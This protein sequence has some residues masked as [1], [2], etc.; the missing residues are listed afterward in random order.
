MYK[1]SF[2]FRSILAAVL[3]VG[4]AALASSCDD[5]NAIGLGLLDTGANG[6]DIA[7][8]LD[9][10]CLS[11]CD[12]DQGNTE[13]RVAYDYDLVAAYE[14]TWWDIWTL[15]YEDIY[16]EEAVQDAVDAIPDGE[17]RVLTFAYSSLIN[18]NSTDVDDGDATGGTIRQSD[19]FTANFASGNTTPPDLSGD[20]YALTETLTLTNCVIK[21]DILPE[22]AGTVDPLEAIRLNGTAVYTQ[23]DPGT[24]TADDPYVETATGRITI[25]ADLNNDGTFGDDLWGGEVNFDV[26]YTNFEGSTRNGGLCFGTTVAFG[27][28]DDGSDDD[29]CADN[30]GGFVAASKIYPLPPP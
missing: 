19:V 28:D 17:E 29:D 15:W 26:E 30:A 24:E 3:L 22:P 1:H 18:C 21:A 16:G 2:V 8:S 10:H 5:S 23:F 25:D 7:D 12:G 9:T 14:L 6:A 4:G 11:Y 27:E 13:L 20:G